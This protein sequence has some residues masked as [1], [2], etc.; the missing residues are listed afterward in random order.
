MKRPLQRRLWLLLIGAVII[1]A[2]ASAEQTRNVSVSLKGSRAIRFSESIDKVAVANPRVADVK[3][4]GNRTLQVLG[5][6]I[7]D[8]TVLVSDTRGQ[9]T[10]VVVSV[11]APT[12]ALAARLRSIFP[13]ESIAVRPVGKTLVL[14]GTVGDPVVARR[15]LQLANAYLQQ[16]H[17]DKAEALSFL[18]VR[19]RQQVQLRVKIA[20][21]SRTAMR[22][23]GVN[24]WARG[25]RYAGGILAPGT[26]VITPEVN[27]GLLPNGADENPVPIIA[28]PLSV[29][30]FGL[31]LSAGGS[32]PLGVAVNLMQGRGLAKILSEPTLVAYSGQTADFLVGGEFP[33]LIPQGL[34]QATIEFKKFGVALNFT[35][36]VLANNTVHLKVAV[37]VSERAE[38]VILQG[39]QVPSLTTR[40][41]ET[42]VRMRSGQSFAIA[43]LL[44]DQIVSSKSKIPL[45]G[46]LPLVGVLFRQTTFERRERELV[47]LVTPY[48][49]RPLKPGEVPP[50]PGEDEVSDPGAAAFFLLGSIDPELKGN[51]SRSRPAGPVGYSQ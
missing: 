35:P 20:E 41:S 24:V 14:T 49:V 30:P 28:G 50:L 16:Q 29:T 6:R 23:I 18:Q 42:T 33:I 27:P 31:H 15:A 21:V 7:G 19:G 45:L 38:E 12:G 22:E 36:T 39:T 48:L 47:I 37:S 25:E 13:E 2:S 44:Q 32:F 51:I 5:K 17:G 34:G 26:S 43:G 40:H 3:V 10:R 46:D 11:G 9:V 8:T 1:A 4:L